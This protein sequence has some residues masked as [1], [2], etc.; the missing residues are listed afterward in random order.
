[1]TEKG[2][3][4]SCFRAPFHCTQPAAL[5]FFQGPGAKR[6]RFGADNFFDSAHR[7]INLCKNHFTTIYTHTSTASNSIDLDPFLLQTVGLSSDYDAVHFG[8]DLVCEEDENMSDRIRRLTRYNTR[9][10]LP[11]VLLVF[12]PLLF[13]RLGF[14]Q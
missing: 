3:F 12:E 2:D 13:R 14:R 7:T 4:G 1:V 10:T 11:V 9:S 6:A 5:T 8:G